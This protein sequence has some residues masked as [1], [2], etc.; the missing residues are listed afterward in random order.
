MQP[1]RNVPGCDTPNHGVR[2]FVRQDAVEFRQVLQR[3]PDGQA[4]L[5][6]ESTA[7]PLRRSG[8]VAKLL[9][10]IEDDVDRRAGIGANQLADA[11][12]GVGEHRSR[13]H[14]KPLLDWSVEHHGEAIVLQRLVTPVRRRFALPGFEAVLERVVPG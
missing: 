2:Q 10:G 6:V 13:A 1:R 12:E 11:P 4:Y 3:T 7:G 9:L 8:D 5:S 14:R